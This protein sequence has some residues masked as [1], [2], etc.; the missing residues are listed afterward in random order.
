MSTSIFNLFMFQVWFYL[1]YRFLFHFYLEK[2]FQY[3]FE[4]R[5]SMA[6]FFLSCSL[7]SPSPSFVSPSHPVSSPPPQPC[8]APA[9]TGSSFRSLQSKPPPTLVHLP[10]PSPSPLGQPWLVGHFPA[11]QGSLQIAGGGGTAGHEYR[12][13]CYYGTFFSKWNSAIWHTV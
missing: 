3:F 6:A 8:S 12:V 2:T 11:S 4:D 1:S 9:G 7:L 5:F 13:I 10:S